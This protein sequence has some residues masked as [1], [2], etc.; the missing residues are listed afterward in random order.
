MPPLGALGRANARR[1][2]A[3]TGGSDS[4]NGQRLLAIALA[5]QRRHPQQVASQLAHTIALVGNAQVND[6]LADAV[7][8]RLGAYVPLADADV[9]TVLPYPAGV[10]VTRVRAWAGSAVEGGIPIAVPGRVG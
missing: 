10:Q 9:L 4:E 8:G 1:P 5:E 3:G 7:V 6:P 2:H